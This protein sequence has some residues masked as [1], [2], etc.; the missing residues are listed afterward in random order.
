MSDRW[1]ILRMSGGSTLPVVNALTDAS[2][3][4]WTPVVAEKKRTGSSRKE[5][6]RPT[7]LI[8]GI[9]F[10]QADRLHDLI[11]MSRAPSLTH[12]RYNRDTGRMELRGCPAFSVF[13]DQGHYPLISDAQLEA[14]RRAE[15]KGRS[16]K[17]EHVF[18]PNDQVRCDQTS[19]AGMVGVVSRVSK[20]R[21]RVLWP[22]AL[23]EWEFDACD[24][25]PVA[26]A[27]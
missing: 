6:E 25:I 23:H 21:V 14:L 7:A 1:C 11:V 26:Q 13:R 17:A 27:A 16:R 24:L 2:F 8:P 19:Y 20:K 3:T 18:H 15:W 4:V 9:V 5:I 22:E 12:R 10:A